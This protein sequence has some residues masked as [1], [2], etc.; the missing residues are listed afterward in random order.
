M[1]RKGFT[2]LE[3]LVGIVLFAVGVVALAQMQVINIKGTAFEKDALTAV[4]L[5]EKRI[6]EL[7]STSF[8]LIS[9][10]TVGIAEQGMT[11]TW[12]VTT[13]GTAPNRCKNIKVDVK[14]TGQAQPLVTLTSIISEV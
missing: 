13:S 7:K 10:N 6:E 3:V 8:G 5:G 14:W 11:T 4:T 2:L 12:T 1:D 9:E